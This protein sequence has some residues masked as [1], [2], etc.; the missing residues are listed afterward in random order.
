MTLCYT[1]MHLFA[2]ATQNLMDR[3]KYYPETG[4]QRPFDTAVERKTVLDDKYDETTK[5][6]TATGGWERP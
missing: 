1:C 4:P 6:K 2:F 5:A 3:A